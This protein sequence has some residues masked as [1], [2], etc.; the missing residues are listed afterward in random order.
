MQIKAVVFDFD[1]VLADTELDISA[2]IQA[3]QRHYGA[4]VM[5]KTDIIACVGFGAKYLVDK[6]VPIGD[7][8]K[9]AEVLRWYKKYY[10]AHPCDETVLFPGV[11]ETLNTF[12]AKG[13]PMSIV[14]NKPE[15]ITKLVV[16]ALG[17]EEY[18]TSIVGPESVTQ[19]KPHP[20]GLILSGQRMFAVLGE[21]YDPKAC[22]M[23][24]DT[25][26]DIVAGKAA[27]FGHTCAVLY[28]YGDR[29]KLLAADADYSVQHGQ[30][31]ARV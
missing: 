4:P 24:G 22:M 9:M 15:S 26:T 3:T 8:T 19:V 29:D 23:V 6:T 12:K 17:I 7:D 10:E 30:E 25:Y 13:I 20:E 31:I 1:G 14:S 16:K 18:F 11:L 5:S 28:G 21:P 27:G 2:S